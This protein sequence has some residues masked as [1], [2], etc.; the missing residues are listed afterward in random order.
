MSLLPTL[1]HQ[2]ATGNL[3]DPRLRVHPAGLATHTCCLLGELGRGQTT[4]SLIFGPPPRLVT[5]YLE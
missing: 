5:N 4:Q 3:A 1:V 2:D